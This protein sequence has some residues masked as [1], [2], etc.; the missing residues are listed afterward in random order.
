MHR[1]AYQ[2][3]KL[4]M[5][6]SQRKAL[7]RGQAT[8]LVLHESIQTTEAKAREL[9]PYFERLVTKAKL[10]NLVG[11]RALEASL[12]NPNAVSKMIQELAPALA[13]RSGGYTRIT[14]LGSRRGDNANMAIV[15]I[16]LPVKIAKP[17]PPAAST[18]ETKPAK[19]EPTETKPA[20]VAAAKVEKTK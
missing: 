16:V 3:R 5:T 13:D 18:A 1:H 10:N 11:K 19:P 8:A 17:S 15:S 9:A 12:L 2:G 14:K 7:I 20:K 6:A 4:S